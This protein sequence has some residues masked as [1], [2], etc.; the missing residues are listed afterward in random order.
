MVTYHVPTLGTYVGFAVL[1]LLLSISAFIS[2]SE[3]AFFSLRPSDLEKMREVQESE[4]RF[5]HAFRMLDNQERLL[6]TILI[7]N[8]LVNV[9][10]VIL[11]NYVTDTIVTFSESSVAGFLVKMVLI[12]F[13]LLLFGEIM[14]KQFAAGRQ[15]AY[16]RR[17][18]RLLYGFYL[19][20]RPISSFLAWSVRK[21]NQRFTPRM[22]L[23]M[24]ELGEALEI[25]QGQLPEED[26]ILKRIVSYGHLEVSEIMRPRLDTV[27]VDRETDFEVLKNTVISSG[28]S[29]LPV[30]EETLDSVVGVLYV[31]D[32]LRYI[33]ESADFD[34]F[35]LVR[36]A[37]F[38]PENKKIN[39]LFTEF[40]RERIHLAIV[41]DEYGGTCGVVTLE[42]IL[43]EIF[44][45]IGDE[46]DFATQLYTKL[47]DRCY[48]FVAKVQLNDLCKVL[49]ID[50]TILEDVRGEAETIGGLVLEQLGRF[51]ERGEVLKLEEAGLTL[52]VES[53][54][55]RRIEQIKVEY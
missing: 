13:L 48:R 29:R 5:T 23:S 10:I 6:A 3:S 8:N 16:V 50:D 53:V 27:A 52:T 46:S 51:P 12:T 20:W 37:Y 19:F 31:K 1:L 9:G 33:D 49:D 4:G 30:Y 7:T 34:W 55:S 26:A 39:D 17:A 40:Q 35:K 42:D 41:V 32:L 54:S 36:K 45:E 2:G 18:D 25:T 15:L 38:V 22:Q 11:A 47:G 43:E 21:L 14:P 44:G 24:D 28:Y